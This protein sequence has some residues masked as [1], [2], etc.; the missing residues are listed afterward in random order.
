VLDHFDEGHAGWTVDAICERLDLSTSSGYRYLRELTAAGL[1][2]R[3]TGGL[4]VRERPSRIIL[5]RPHLW[6]SI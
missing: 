4:F 6:R 3:L 5:D 2:T 1:L